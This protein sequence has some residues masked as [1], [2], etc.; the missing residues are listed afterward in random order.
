[1]ISG[2]TSLVG[3]LGQ[4]VNHSLSPAIQ[5]AAMKEMGLDWCYLAM[6]CEAKN[7]EAITTAL[8]QINCK[9]LNITIPHK[10]SVIDVCKNITPLAKRL[11]AINT[12]VPSKEGG[13]NGMNT[14]VE[15]FLAPLQ[16]RNWQKGKVIILGCGGSAR[17]VITGLESLNFSQI[18]VIGRRQ[19][20][21]NNFL[22]S[23]QAKKLKPEKNSTFLQGLMQESEQL[24]HEI[25][26]ADLIIN[27]TPVGMSAKNAS[28]TQSRA[29]PLGENIWQHLLPKTTLYDLIYTPQPTAWLSLGSENG[30]ESINGLEMLI[31][32]GAAS[33]RLW[34]NND[35][36]PIDVMRKAAKQHLTT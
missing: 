17:A 21:L 10:Q 6:P 12:L 5:N 11:G 29:I 13:W 16:D 31:Q 22:M 26:E 4:P 18:T 24:I 36:V 34:S 27:T 3:L 28:K 33:L 19:N 30:C 20:T 14:D 8:L 7:L 32:Q 1:M 23:F 2:T 9:G 15:G 25:K 35:E